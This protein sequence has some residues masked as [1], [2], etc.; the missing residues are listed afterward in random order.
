MKALAASIKE[1]GWAGALLYNET[2]ARLI[3]GHARKQC[4]LQAAKSSRS[5]LVPVLVGRWTEEQERRIL[6]TLD[7]I[8]A[9]AE[10]DEQALRNLTERMDR[11]LEQATKKM[12]D[13]TR[14]T[15]HTITRELNSEAEAVAY[16]GPSSF[17]PEEQ[18]DSAPQPE[19]QP[20][21][22]IDD[23]KGELVGAMRLKSRDEVDW[24]AWGPGSVLDIPHLRTDRLG[25]I[26]EPITTWLGPKDS[27][28]CDHY[29]YLFGSTAL[30]HAGENYVVAFYVQD[31]RF[32]RVWE[33]P[34]TYTAN[35]LN[36]GVTT[37][38][39]PNFS[40][41]DGMHKAL[42]VYHTYRARWLS[43]YWQEVGLR[44]I[45]DLMLGNLIH[46]EVWRWRFAGIPKNAPA[47]ALQVQQKGERD[48][49]L[50]YRQ[51]HRQLLK[52]LDILTPSSLLLYHG[53]NLP[54]WFVEKLPKTL[55]VVRCLSFMSG[56]SKTMREKLYPHRA[57]R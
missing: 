6:A 1:N 50:Y 29:L 4:A 33:H 43:R 47:V 44:V 45:P 57:T 2:T 27:E 32:E 54:E 46:D 15:F 30:G 26:P 8:S 55:H 7:P 25:A 49:D 38:I 10:M 48:P 16:G 21:A 18:E 17:F 51:R 20:S 24:D 14:E 23:K 11:D 52:V 37:I 56:R 12:Q 31:D 53:P 3:D 41:Y 34:E 40:C 19:A 13:E 28:P 35:L 36:L 39:S 42:D 5:G 22:G 9:M